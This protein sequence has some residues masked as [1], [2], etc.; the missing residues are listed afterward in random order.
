MKKIA[1]LVLM[2]LVCAAPAF[3]R[4]KKAPKDPRVVEHPKAYHP[5]NQQYK[6]RI[7]PK[8]HK[9]TSYQVK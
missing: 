1:V 8:T 2:L 9:Q 7:K 6:K 5:K 4:H 3:A